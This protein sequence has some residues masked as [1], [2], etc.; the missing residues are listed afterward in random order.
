MNCNSPYTQSDF[1]CYLCFNYCKVADI[2][3]TIRKCLALF[4][5][6]KSGTFFRRGISIPFTSLQYTSNRICKGRGLL[7]I[8]LQ[9]FT[10]AYLLK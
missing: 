8:L 9:R 4:P 2:S 10:R 1:F 6:I 5:E 3:D 7:L